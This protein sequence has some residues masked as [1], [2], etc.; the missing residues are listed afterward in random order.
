[1]KS[2]TIKEAFSFG[3]SKYKEYWKF[4]V[5]LF[6]ALG[7]FYALVSWGSNP[8][9]DPQEANWLVQAIGNI[10]GVYISIGIIN[11][12]LRIYRG[13]RIEVKNLFLSWD[14]FWKS[15]IGGILVSLTVLVG[16]ILLIVPGLIWMFTYYFYSYIIIEKAVG[17]IEAMKTSRKITV[18]DRWHLVGFTIV[19][20]LANIVGAMI[21]GI[22]LLVSIPLTS[23]ATV[24]VYKKLQEKKLDSVPEHGI[25]HPSREA[26]EGEAG[27]I[28][29]PASSAGSQ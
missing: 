5:P 15:I 27:G 12:Y 23:L 13:E 28:T 16:F 18:G 8:G 22:G 14:I 10:I 4:L 19:V 25:T 26:T 2:F 17:P 20:V 29:S 6:I 1:M 11:V 9:G 24:W 3:W 21:V 7:I